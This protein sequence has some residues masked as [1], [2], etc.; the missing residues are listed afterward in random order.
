MTRWLGIVGAWLVSAALVGAVGAGI[1]TQFVLSRL[2]TA[3]AGAIPVADRLNGALRDAI[4]LGPLYAG[5][6]LAPLAIALALASLL[7][8]RGIWRFGPFKLA[9]ALAVLATLLAL[10]TVFPAQPISGATGLWGFLAQ[11]AAG[12]LGGV[13]FAA[14]VRPRR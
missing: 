3:G 9:G 13:L 12:A 2:E 10:Q 14:L 8:I 11:M 6:V 4:G 7:P 5:F 1:A